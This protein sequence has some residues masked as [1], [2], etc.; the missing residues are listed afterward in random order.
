[1]QDLIGTVKERY[2]KSTSY[3]NLSTL[4]HRTQNATITEELKPE[5]T[6]KKDFFDFLRPQLSGISKKLHEEIGK[7]LERREKTVLQTINRDVLRHT[8]QWTQKWKTDSVKAERTRLETMKKSDKRLELFMADTEAKLKVMRREFDRL[9]AED[10]ARRREHDKMTAEDL[11]LSY[12]AAKKLTNEKAER[13]RE[14]IRRELI[15]SAANTERRVLRKLRDE[16]EY[17]KRRKG[18]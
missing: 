5:K 14:D 18:G 11:P 3:H 7:L 9:K 2:G 8:E 16:E 6:P 12:R 17:E 15:T 1:M 4:M 13:E 10:N